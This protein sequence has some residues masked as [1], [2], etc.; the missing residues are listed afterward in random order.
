MWTRFMDMHSGGG[1]KVKP[2]EYIY[3]EAPED[4]AKAVFFNRFGRNPSRVT[5]TCCGDDYNIEQYATLK[6]ATAFERNCDY[7]GDKYVERQEPRKIGIRERCGTAV[8]DPWG[9][10]V[11]VEQYV[12]R[13][14]VLVIRKKEIK[15]SERKA[16][17]PQQGYVWVD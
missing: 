8:S 1:T 11:T 9:L 3:I 17:I 6:E 5:C 2:Y 13:P 4:E 7:E 15:A 16:A 14:D 12:Q 10:Y